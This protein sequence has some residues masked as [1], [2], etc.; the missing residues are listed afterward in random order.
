VAALLLDR[1]ADPNAK[2]AAGRTPLI[3]AAMKGHTAVAALLLER[4]ADPALQDAEGL[5]AG[6]WAEQRGQD[7]VTDLLDA[8]GTRASSA[9]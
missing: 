9:D 1:G 7:G 3:Q 4:G 5:K 8:F 2:D 6:D